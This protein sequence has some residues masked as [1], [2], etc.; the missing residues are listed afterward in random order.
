M[1]PPTVIRVAPC[2]RSLPALLPAVAPA[3]GPTNDNYDRW[4]VNNMRVVQTQLG[5]L[6]SHINTIKEDA[7]APRGVEE[8]LVAICTALDA[9]T[10]E[11][12]RRLPTE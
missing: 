1:V 11:L 6:E 8:A 2:E 9:L 7:A 10:D 5:L 4:M 12:R 3:R